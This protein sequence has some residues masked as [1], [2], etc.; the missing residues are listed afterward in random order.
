MTM[1]ELGVGDKVWFFHTYYGFQ[2]DCDDGSII[3]P[4]GITLISGVVN[5]IDIN[6][7]LVWVHDEESDSLYSLRYTYY[8]F[9]IFPTK[10]KALESM[11]K[12]I[13]LL[14]VIVV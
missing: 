7:D 2:K 14:Q 12:N 1:V 6:M 13:K 8:E 9:V 5:K 4:Q 10:E 3:Y 11:F